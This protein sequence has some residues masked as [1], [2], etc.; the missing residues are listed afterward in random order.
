MNREYCKEQNK[1]MTRIE[2][3]RLDVFFPQGVIDS[4]RFKNWI[5][6][7]DLRT[8]AECRANHGKVYDRFDAPDAKPPLHTKCRC[9]IE[10]MR[11]IPAGAATKDGLNGADF[12]LK[13]YGTLPNYYISK[14]QLNALGWEYGDRPSKFAPG[15]MLGGMP[16]DNKDMHLPNQTG[17]VWYEADINYTPG[18]RN[19]HRVLWSN[20]GL[21]FV[22]YDH[23]RSFYQVF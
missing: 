9:R 23:Y 1:S 5:T 14:E 15:R 7:L 6:Q 13:Y 3:G 17:R 4:M 21:I 20:D 11:A 2:K 12:W 18:R 22:T 8:C 16:Y 10:N 19:L